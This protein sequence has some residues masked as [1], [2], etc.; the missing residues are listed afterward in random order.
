M[1]PILN[2]L[3]L[4]LLFG[5][6]FYTLHAQKP[7]NKAGFW[8]VESNVATPQSATVYF[9]NAQHQMVYKEIVQNIKLDVTKAKV[10]RQLNAVLHQSIAAW[11]R[12]H[13]VLLASRMQ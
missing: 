2:Y 1:K 5:M 10:R 4:A 9:Y 8:V 11:K 6:P 12:E 7:M 3:L 13:K